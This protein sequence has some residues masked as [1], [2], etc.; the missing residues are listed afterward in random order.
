MFAVTRRIWTLKSRS[1]G[2]KLHCA[3]CTSTALGKS[4]R[5]PLL[6]FPGV[7]WDPVQRP[8]TTHAHDLSWRDTDYCFFKPLVSGRSLETQDRTQFLHLRPI[9]ESGVLNREREAENLPQKNIYLCLGCLNDLSC[10]S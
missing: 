10:T 6:P 1:P 4:D 3:L 5:F 2:S 9:F 8:E 7:N